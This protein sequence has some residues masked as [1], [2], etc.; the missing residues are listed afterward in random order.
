VAPL[1]VKA[2][3]KHPLISIQG[4]KYTSECRGNIDEYF[5]SDVSTSGGFV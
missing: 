1:R 4:V 2:D 3:L 5:S